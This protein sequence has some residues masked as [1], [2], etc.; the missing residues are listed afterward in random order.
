MVNSGL[1]QVTKALSQ[2]R[3]LAGMSLSFRM[4]LR[5]ASLRCGLIIVAA[6]P[7]TLEGS[8]TGF[9]TGIAACDLPAQLR[10][11]VDLSESAGRWL[12]VRGVADPGNW[13]ARWRTRVAL[14]KMHQRGH[15]LCVLLMPIWSNWPRG[16]RAGNF[17]RLPVDL[18]D[19][20]GWGLRLGKAYGDLVDAWEI[21]NEPDIGFMQENAE[22]YAAYLKAAYLGIKYGS[23]SARSS[24]VLMA[25]LALPPGPH[26]EALAQNGIFSYTDGFNFH[27]YGHAEDFSG[28]Y[29]QFEKAT[30]ELAKDYANDSDENSALGSEK[31]GLSVAR[32]KLPVFLT[33]FGYG[34][35]SGAAA[36]TVEG[37]VRQWQWFRDVSAQIG[38]LHIE[39]P[40]A[41]Y[42]SPYLEN[43]TQEFGLTMISKNHEPRNE[44]EGTANTF[45][46]GGLTFQ[47][48]D[49]GTDAVEPWMNSIGRR[50]GQ[51][52]VSPALAWLIAEKAI[53]SNDS[54]GWRIA[55]TP[56]PRVVIDF[57]A[58]RGMLA[59]KQCHGYFLGGATDGSSAGEGE[60]RI[61]NFGSTA[62]SGRLDFG[63]FA[64]SSEAIPEMLSLAPG[65]MRIIP[66]KLQ[67][68]AND[69]LPHKWSAR[70][71]EEQAGLTDS[72]FVTQLYANASQMSRRVV[73][74]LGE[75][76][77]GSRSAR[78]LD[79]REIAVEEPKEEKSGRW[80]MTKGVKVSEH[81]GTWSFTV[82][83]FPS[84]P[85]RP[86]IAEL[87][88]P[89]G[90]Q[91]PEG[92]LLELE[93]RLATRT[94][95]DCTPV[96]EPR[97]PVQI[98]SVNRELIGISWRTE[99]GNLYTVWQTPPATNTWQKYAQA[100]GSFTMG[101]YGRANLPWRFSDN[102]PVALVFMFRP[103]FLPATYEV[104]NVAIT[105][106]VRP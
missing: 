11:I 98:A 26:L 3:L 20:Y 84:E 52:V 61:Y 16:T 76:D 85:L 50:I 51:G 87:V 105:S 42:L 14:K 79:A 29:R 65:E 72:V 57:V 34:T 1:S 93:Y 39:G 95:N 64:Q 15:R 75:A 30:Q 43:G 49:F 47:P 13:F 68:A 19:A 40:M 78:V 5:A 97:A 37:R 63:K 54:N 18:R 80:R 96:S 100:K 7:L 86:A 69:L 27:Y 71:I 70:F 33:E 2:H 58:G 21:D 10:S 94:A 74:E 28:V 31:N 55:S 67:M 104:K 6:I 90:F 73:T 12:R 81:S 59:V 41:F 62:A 56:A 102:R 35:L 106:Y 66:V 83:E 60:L 77:A 46:A 32:K 99:N 101:F 45:T 4:S 17:S 25:P 88:L 82:S 53:G 9:D 92:S 22:N 103:N 89:D 8:V 91:M 24:L 38:R 48:R 23:G 44:N 36:G